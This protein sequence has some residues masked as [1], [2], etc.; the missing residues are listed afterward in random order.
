MIITE[1][2]RESFEAVTRPVIEWLNA[3]CHPHVTVII[4]TS[5]AELHEGVYAY[6]T[7]DYLRD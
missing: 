1:Q 5:R 2:Q 7:T 4:E 6:P 3:N